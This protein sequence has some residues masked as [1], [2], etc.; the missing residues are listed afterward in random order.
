MDLKVTKS[1]PS[2]PEKTLLSLPLAIR[3][4]ILC[5]ESS[6]EQLQGQVQQQQD[7][8]QQQ[9]DQIQ[10]LQDQIQQL[11]SQIAQLQAQLSK[12]SSNSSKPP[13][14]DGLKRK[15]KSLREKSGKKPGA[16]QGHPGKGLSLV[17]NP[18][19]III[20]EPT[21]CQACGSDLSQ[22][23]GVFRERRQVFDI[24]LPKLEVSEHQVFAKKCPKCSKLN[25]ADFPQGVKGSVQYGERV[26]GLSSYLMH[27]HF[28][29]VDRTCQFLKDVF[30]LTLSPGT[31]IKIERILFQQLEAFEK[32]LKPYLLKEHVLYFDETGTRC[33]KKLKW[34]HVV[35]SPQATLYHLHPQRGQVAMDA[36]GILPHFKGVAVHDE[37]RSYSYYQEAKHGLCNAHI[38]RELT[39]IHEEEKENWA[40]EMKE[41]LIRAKQEVA[42]HI[43][44][45]RLP[46]EK[47]DEIEKKYQH[48]IS[49]GKEYH[50]SLS[51][52][53]KGKRGKQKQRPGKNL[54]D[55]L[56]YKVSCVLGFM[57]DFS[58]QFTNNQSERDIRM[59]K[60]KEKIA[61]CFRTYSGGE[62]FCRIRS[63][64]STSH[65]QGWNVLEALTSAIR[66]D[67]KLLATT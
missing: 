61:G 64:I 16:Q 54:L 46:E 63:Y 26:Q 17:N 51:A 34:T 21:S 55:R 62:N 20:H 48:I 37:W 13:S 14:S 7:Q 4:Y 12:N 32:D 49:Q 18:D 57:K 45:G 3:S 9:Q 15:P 60:V 59:I 28:M 44:E 41:L 52:L 42:K 39:F 66:G 47:L 29:P 6:V 22:Q 40:K 25:Q 53:P 1:N 56:E 24:P 43:A 33:E 67:P 58:V 31:C 23:E 35:S 10:Q 8:V 36:I 19:K 5:L 38:L 50:A 11:Q 65:K 2:L 30:N 27:Q